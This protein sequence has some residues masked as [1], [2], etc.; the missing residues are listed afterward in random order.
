MG[1]ETD[2]IVVLPFRP[3]DYSSN[4]TASDDAKNRPE[5]DI[6]NLRVALNALVRLF[7]M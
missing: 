4:C 5:Q 2:F 6:E 7:R 3:S 1:D